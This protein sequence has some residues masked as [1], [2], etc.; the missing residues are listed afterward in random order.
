MR[1]IRLL[2]KDLAKEVSGWVDDDLISEDQGHA[3]CARYD[4]S[5][6]DTDAQ[7]RGYGLLVALG[8][9]FIGLALITLIGA[10]WDEIPRGLRMAA[11]VLLT[12]AT[13]GFALKR[14]VSGD[15]PSA[16]RFFLLGNLFYGAAIILIAQ[17]YHLGEHMPDGVF[18]WALGSL[19]FGVLLRN[20]WLTL[21]SAVL[22][23]VWFYLEYQMGFFPTLF[24]L[25]MV[26]SAY[27]LVRGP[28]STLLFLAFVGG[29]MLWVEAL[30][31]WFWD[32]GSYAM[33]PQP[34]HLL[35]TVALFILAFAFSQWLIRV[36]H[37][38]ARDYGVVLSVWS[39]RFALFALL[40]MS[41]ES[42]WRALLKED[43][44]HQ[45][46]MW[47][48][49]GILLSAA[50]IVARAAKQ[51]PM[52]SVICGY[53]LLQMLAVVMWGSPRAAASLQ[54]ID[55]VALIVVG[56]GLILHGISRGVS[57]Y[58]FMGIAT[59]LLT[60]FMRYVDLIGDYIGGAFL[61]L[62]LAAVLLGA[63]RFWKHQ[64]LKTND[65]ATGSGDK[66]GERRDESQ[67][68]SPVKNTEENNHD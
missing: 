34:E 30:L 7:S 3:I 31:G 13:H 49:V 66:Q 65:V 61:F 38:R 12:L 6:Q 39:L 18:W 57:H 28:Q 40:I 2:K 51:L 50:L 1:L 59:I 36:N 23:L 55:N 4:V 29:S 9:L 63:A 22:S 27:V 43:W 37:G 8:Y 35:V 33:A 45:A 42:P 10:N 67:T 58:F 14:Y 16:S 60:A 44:L 68:K 56:I 24:P 19:P 5:L 47:P 62:M 48:M 15:E 52:V 21:F 17:I 25:F 54:V 11:L 32:G 41:F 20:T 53:V 26:A 64:Q 46:S